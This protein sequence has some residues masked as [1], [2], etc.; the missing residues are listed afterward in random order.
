MAARILL[1]Y[2]AAQGLRMALPCPMEDRRIAAE[3]LL[4]TLDDR[5]LDRV[6]ASAQALKASR[7]HG[8][9]AEKEA[10]LDRLAARLAARLADQAKVYRY[11]TYG[12][13]DAP[14]AA[15]GGAADLQDY[16][17]PIRVE[18]LWLPVHGWV[19]YD[20]PLSPGQVK[21]YGLRVI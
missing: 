14:G 18:G 7:A 11:Y 20:S 15:P 6:I 16:G 8:A 17:A 19:E 4:V 3:T 5:T 21:A 2:T 13:P 9:A 1:S 12:P 10:L